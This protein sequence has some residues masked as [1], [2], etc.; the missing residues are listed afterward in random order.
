MSTRFYRS[1]MATFTAN[2]VFKNLVALAEH[3]NAGLPAHK[4]KIEVGNDRPG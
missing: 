2:H 4:E 1:K 3:P